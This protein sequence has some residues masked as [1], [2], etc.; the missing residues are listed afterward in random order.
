M[1]DFPVRDPLHLGNLCTVCTCNVGPWSCLWETAVQWTNLSFRRRIIKEP[2]V[3]LLPTAIDAVG[4]PSRAWWTIHI[5]KRKQK[6]GLPFLENGIR[7]GPL[8]LQRWF[9]NVIIHLGLCMFESK[10]FLTVPYVSPIQG[11]KFSTQPYR[12]MTPRGKYDCGYEF[13]LACKTWR[14]R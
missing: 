14:E 1:F 11:L 5:R 9:Q 3:F 7:S 6:P 13:I 2:Q 12:F 8:L 4:L 10:I